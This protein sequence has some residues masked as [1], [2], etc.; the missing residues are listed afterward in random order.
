MEQAGSD[1]GL[2]DAL[3]QLIDAD[4]A[5]AHACE[6]A[7]GRLFDAR[8]AQ[9]VRRL[10]NDH[11]RHIGQLSALVR[12]LGGEPRDDRHDLLTRSRIAFGDIL[13]DRGVLAALKSIEDDAL[14]R[15]DATLTR[16]QLPQEIRGLIEQM[17]AEEH[18]H[19]QWLALRLGSL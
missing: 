1:N 14:A 6:A 11:Q 13:G 8:L 2:V 10:Q 18:R 9:H 16:R 4:Y 17:V 3:N 12:D 19:Q 7:A 5:A 15:S